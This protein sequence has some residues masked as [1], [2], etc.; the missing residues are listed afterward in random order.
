MTPVGG[1]DEVGRGPWAGPVVAAAA[2]F[3]SPSSLPSILL[4]GIQDSKKLSKDKREFIYAELLKLDLFH[5]GVG[6]A[7]VEE[8]D[9]LNIL[10]ATFLAMERSI[11]S[12]PQK[13]ETLLIDGKYIPSFEGIQTYPLIKGDHISFSIAAASIIAKVTRDRLM[14]KLAL[15]HPHYG[16]ERNAGYGT[17]EHQRALKLHGITPHH[18]RSFAPIKS[19]LNPP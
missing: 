17:V 11:Q 6:M 3:L 19:L 10:K 5:H 1:V 14:E 9:Q 16:W 13:P 4:K 18:R 12:L 15:E 7:S 8:I 2:V